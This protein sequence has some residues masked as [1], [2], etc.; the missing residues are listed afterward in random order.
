ML[1]QTDRK[2]GTTTE[3][4]TAKKQA[5]LLNH[6]ILPDTCLAFDAQGALR[7]KRVLEPRHKA[8]GA[9]LNEPGLKNKVQ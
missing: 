7:C 2:R 5:N 4:G 1:I 8:K 9:R 6:F 3:S